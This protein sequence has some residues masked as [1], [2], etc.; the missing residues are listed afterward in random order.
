VDC[1]AWVMMCIS[2]I[3]IVLSISARRTSGYG[4]LRAKVIRCDHWVDI[5]PGIQE[6]I[7][8]LVKSEGAIKIQ[9]IQTQ[10][11]DNSAVIVIIYE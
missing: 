6:F 7:D 11:D 2:A 3:L 10:I 9:S 4:Q 5:Q 1:F 8:S